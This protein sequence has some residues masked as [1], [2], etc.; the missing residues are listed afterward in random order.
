[1]WVFLIQLAITALLSIALKPKAESPRPQSMSDVN[2]P[3]ADPSAAIPVIFGTVMVRNLNT[4]WWGDT[5]T[6]PIKTKSGKK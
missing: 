1:M 6:S 3:K 5:S 4:V 2:V